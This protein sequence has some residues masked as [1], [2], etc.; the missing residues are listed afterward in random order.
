MER[1]KT[2]KLA[3]FEIGST[4]LAALEMEAQINRY[5]GGSAPAERAAASPQCPKPL[6]QKPWSLA[7][8]D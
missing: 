6:Y 4:K 1:P 2:T 5:G 3:G 8:R 7:R